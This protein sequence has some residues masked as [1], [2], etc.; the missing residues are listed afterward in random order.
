MNFKTLI[1]IAAATLVFFMT[2]PP[3]ELRWGLFIFVL[4]GALWMTQA[5][6]LSVTALLIPALAA[7]TGLMPLPQALAAFANPIIFLFLGGF[8]LAAALKQQ[9]LDK[10]LAVSLV[11]L[12]RGHSLRAVL[13]LFGATAFLSMWISNTAAVVIMLPL[14]L[15]LINSNSALL[16]QDKAF[17]LLGIAYSGSIGGIGTLIGSPPNAIAAAQTGIRFGEWLRFGI[18]MVALLL[19][20]MLGALYISLKPRIQGHFPMT[21]TKVDWD[22]GKIATVCI[23]ALTALGWIFAPYLGEPLGMV[24]QTDA[25]VAI[26][27]ILL[28]TATGAIQWKEIEAQCEWGILLL[29]GGGL[30]LSRIMDVSGGSSYLATLLVEHVAQM[31]VLALILLVVAFVVFMTELV[32]NTASAAL[33]IPIFISLSTALGLDPRLLAIAIAISASCAF[34][35]P[36]ATPPNAIVYATNLVPQ[37]VMMRTGFILN[38]LC[39]AVITVIVLY[40]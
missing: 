8:A 10:A 30:A 27:A 7:L 22:F 1:S 13:Y 4:A 2:P 5:I 28:L 12:A 6:H 36:V 20:S 31:P 24:G 40:F 3:D 23:F 25:V 37:G 35:L 21:Q 9:G 39:I 16:T 15:G 18:P 33:L 14:A 11:Q 29:F 17:I 26:L 34:M 19:P 38:L 32:S